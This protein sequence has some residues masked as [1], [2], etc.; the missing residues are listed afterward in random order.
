MAKTVWKKLNGGDEFALVTWRFRREPYNIFVL[1][2]APTLERLL[3]QIPEHLCEEEDEISVIHIGQWIVDNFDCD[4]LPHPDYITT[5]Y[6]LT[7]R[8]EVP[9]EVEEEAVA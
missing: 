7:Y 3:A 5:L 8:N 1:A 2:T 9:Y 4:S 6:T